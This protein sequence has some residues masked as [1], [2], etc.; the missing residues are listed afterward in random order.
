MA[1]EKKEYDKPGSM[2]EGKRNILQGLPQE[3]SIES[4]ADIRET[5]KDLPAEPS[6]K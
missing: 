6:R 1:N 5:P 3:Y 2:T 4:A